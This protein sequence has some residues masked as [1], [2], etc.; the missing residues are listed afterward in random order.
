MEYESD[1]VLQIHLQTVAPGEEFR[2]TL[3]VDSAVKVEYKNPHK[4]HEQVRL[5]E[6]SLEFLAK[7]IKYIEYVLNFRV[8]T[9]VSVDHLNYLL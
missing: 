9:H 2:C 1:I 6:V 3:G 8:I 5:C 7:F 4:A